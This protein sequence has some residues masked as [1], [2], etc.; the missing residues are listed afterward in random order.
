M[1]FFSQFSPMFQEAK[2][3]DYDKNEKQKVV[4]KLQRVK[5]FVLEQKLLL[6]DD[7]QTIVNK[8]E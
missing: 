4:R 7:I 6:S 1:D 8:Y 2:L 5:G 3:N